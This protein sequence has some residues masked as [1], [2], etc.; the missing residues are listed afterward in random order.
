MTEDTINRLTYKIHR[1]KYGLKGLKKMNG[2]RRNRVEAFFKEASSYLNVYE[3][4][5]CESFEEFKRRSLTICLF[6]IL[7]AM[8]A[9][10]GSILLIGYYFH[11]LI[12]LI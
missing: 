5:D 12:H 9:G 8:G 4:R 6:F 11:L 3:K 1:K 10:F 2:K 7:F